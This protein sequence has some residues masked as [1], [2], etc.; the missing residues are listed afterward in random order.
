MG[1]DGLNLSPLRVCDP[2]WSVPPARVNAG[3][4]HEKLLNNSFE[5]RKKGSLY[6]LPLLIRSC[7]THIGTAIVIKTKKS[8][9]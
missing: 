9:G 7:S 5:G 6:W 3:V 1:C 8:N 4:A 2:V